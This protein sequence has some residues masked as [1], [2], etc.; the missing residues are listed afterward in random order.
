MMWVQDL[1]GS[2][3]LKDNALQFYWVGMYVPDYRW[4]PS[5]TCFSGQCYQVSTRTSCVLWLKMCWVPTKIIHQVLPSTM[6]M[7]HLLEEPDMNMTLVPSVSRRVRVVTAM[8]IRTR[9]P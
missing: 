9:L 5:L 8:P 6:R 2:T 7:I 1:T 4:W 3:E